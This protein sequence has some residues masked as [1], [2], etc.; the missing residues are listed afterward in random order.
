MAE[1]GKTPTMW[2]EDILRKY[3]RVLELAEVDPNTIEEH[4]LRV[5]PTEELNEEVINNE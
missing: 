2:T 4:A 3:L 5:V 1:E